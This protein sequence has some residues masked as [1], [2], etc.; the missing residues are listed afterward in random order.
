MADLLTCN[1]V[2]LM[3]VQCNWDEVIR[4]R[5][6]K[7]WVSCKR[8]GERTIHSTLCCDGTHIDN[9][10]TLTSIRQR[11]IT[12]DCAAAQHSATF[13]CPTKTLQ[14]HDGKLLD[15]DI[16][17][18]G[19]L[20]VCASD[21]GRLWLWDTNTGENKCTLEGHV[22]DVLTCRF[23]PSG[24]VVLS[25][26]MDM[27]LRIWSVHDGSCPR[28]LYGHHGAVT[29]TTMIDRGRNIISVSKDGT[30]RLWDCGSG[31]CIDTVA[32]LGCP[33]NSCSLAS[34]ALA[35]ASAK[36]KPSEPECG[37][38][39]K[40]LLLAC[41]DGSARAYDVSSRK[42][43]LTFG[44]GNEPVTTAAFISEESV[45]CGCADG[46][47]VKFDLRKTSE[48]ISSYSIGA[49]AVYSLLYMGDGRV[50]TGHGDGMCTCWNL[51][52]FSNSVVR[53]TGPDIDHITAVRNAADNVY[54]SCRDGNVRRYSIADFT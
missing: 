4:Q 36:E 34:S 38:S 19:A 40:L 46:D 20:G 25:G 29:E 45:L 31:Q 15:M 5:G 37:T 1:S 13:V 44:I 43:L 23:F 6:S 3:D 51:Q 9:S 17:P 41:E 33:I 21:N 14:L 18:S 22:M 28:T 53:L 7:F 8:R 52:H 32:S 10:F 27:R 50:V 48:C 30:A 35:C 24:M 26:G 49:G 11:A 54:C 39:D 42:L 2:P 47:L 16:S 12:V